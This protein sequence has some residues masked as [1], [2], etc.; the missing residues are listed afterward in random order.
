M[1]LQIRRFCDFATWSCTTPSATEG[2]LILNYHGQENRQRR[3]LLD[4]CYRPSYLICQE[5]LDSSPVWKLP[6]EPL[7][8]WNWHMRS[9]QA[10]TTQTLKCATATTLSSP[11]KCQR[12]KYHARADFVILKVFKQ[13]ALHNG[14]RARSLLH[15]LLAI[16]VPPYDGD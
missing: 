5:L 3:T 7:A 10:F 9:I 16:G 4:R 2:R 11:T 15:R 12:V 13:H 6:L 1:S 14:L 8:Y